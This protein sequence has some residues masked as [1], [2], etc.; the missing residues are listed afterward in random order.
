MKKIYFTVDIETIV[1]G[2]SK[3]SDYLMGGYVSS[4]FI[5]EQLYQRGL[6][7]TFFVS[8][9]SKQANISNHEYLKMIK[10][11]LNSLKAYPNI[12][13]E[14]H[15]HAFNLPMSFPTKYDAFNKYSEQQQIDLLNYS[16]SFFKKHGIDVQAFR[17]GGFSSNSS[18]YNSLKKSGFLYSSILD[19]KIEPSIDLIKSEFSD[20]LNVI[21]KDNG[22]VEFPVSSVR[23]KSIK[24]KEEILNLSPDFFRIDSVQEYIDQLS[25]VNINFHSFSIYLNRLIRE[26]HKSLFTKNLKFLFIEKIL[27]KFVKNT[28]LS[29]YNSD[30]TISKEFINWLDYIQYKGYDTY[31]IGE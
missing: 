12:K 4:M 13:V 27:N 20:N 5:A 9:S 31:F 11:L 6:K 2:L 14:S 23:I 24:G 16:K 3:N 17:P 19:K 28:G 8:L 18:Y 1:S 29:L 10:W 30:T 7:A 22:I 21:M 26:N 25:Y 15:I